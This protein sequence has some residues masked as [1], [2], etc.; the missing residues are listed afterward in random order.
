MAPFFII[1]GLLEAVGESIDCGGF[2]SGFVHR[3]ASRVGVKSEELWQVVLKNMFET[4]FYEITGRTIPF[5]T[6]FPQLTLSCRRSL[7]SAFI[8]LVEKRFL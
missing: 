2:G 4:F 5:T 8:S 6:R 7:T 3:D 1:I